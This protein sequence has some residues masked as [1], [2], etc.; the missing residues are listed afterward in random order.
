M[1]PEIE[2]KVAFHLR[3]QSLIDPAW[4]QAERPD[5][6]ERDLR[7]FTCGEPTGTVSEWCGECYDA[8]YAAFERSMA[9]DLPS[10]PPYV[11]DDDPMTADEFAA[12]MGE[13]DE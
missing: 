2:S 13:D 6:D 5:G 8:T 7:C 10:E 1:T 9:F 4:Q 11:A 3:V 12:W